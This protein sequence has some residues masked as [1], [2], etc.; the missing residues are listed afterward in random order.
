MVSGE[1][2]EIELTV[3]RYGGGIGNLIG[4]EKLNETAAPDHHIAGD[5]IDARCLMKIQRGRVLYGGEAAVGIC[6]RR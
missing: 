3:V 1:V 4:G 5:G 2:Q 6:I